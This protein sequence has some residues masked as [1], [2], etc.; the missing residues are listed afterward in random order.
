MDQALQLKDNTFQDAYNHFT[1]RN[2]EEF[3]TSGQWMTEKRGGSDVCKFLR[4]SFYKIL[5]D[6]RCINNLFTSYCL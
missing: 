3:W 6:L 4:I 1:S 2:P 5:Y